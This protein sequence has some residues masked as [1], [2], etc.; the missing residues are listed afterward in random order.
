MNGPTAIIA[1]DEAPQRAQLRSL[2]AEL[3][4]ELRILAE[5]ADGKQAIA[6]LKQHRPDVNFLDIRMPGAGGLEVA[7][8]IGPAGHIVFITAYD[9]FA[10][11]AFEDGASDYLLK[12][13]KRD[14][15]A[16]A[17]A[18]LKARLASGA[19]TDL[20]AL[21]S[22][23]EGRLARAPYIKWITASIGGAV[24]MLPVD[25]VQL[26]QAAEGP[27]RAARSGHLLAGAS[28]DHR[29]AVG[30]PPDQARRGR[31]AA[32]ASA[33]PDGNPGRFL[34]L[35]AALQGHVA[36]SCS[37]RSARRPSGEAAARRRSVTGR[38]KRS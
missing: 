25:E 21:L 22:R 28:W 30:H 10:V 17:V 6:A 19:Q 20:S 15:L 29:P 32:A 7:R 14:R 27:D 26:F 8:A 4:P 36:Q 34:G 38:A 16:I 1:E 24:K 35:R 11:Q 13:I 5:C 3:W 23:L 2:L 12:P 33:R 9:G 18:R 31:Q 37:S